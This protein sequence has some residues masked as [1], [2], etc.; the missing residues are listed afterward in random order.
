MKHLDMILQK[1]DLS[2]LYTSLAVKLHAF[3]M[4]NIDRQAALRMHEPGLRPYSLFTMTQAQNIV[5]RISI[6]TKDAEVLH[7][8]ARKTKR[9]YVT[10]IGDIETLDVVEH[11]ETAFR[12]L[13]AAPPSHVK[14]LFAS[15]ATYKHGTEYTNMFNLAQLLYSVTDKLRL[16]EEIDIPVSELNGLCETVHFPAYR[17]QNSSYTIKRGN[18]IPGFSGEITLRLD[19][20]EQ[21]KAKLALLLR[22][23]AFSGLGAKT[24]LGMGGIL[25]NE[26]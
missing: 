22:Y 17:L 13:C 1:R 11:E 12:D 10:G 21:E 3:L 6:L 26:K 23:A 15:P 4:A 7:A 25:L 8:A 19:G 14:L 2:V 9:F 18:V 24:A 20:T 16:F 5:F